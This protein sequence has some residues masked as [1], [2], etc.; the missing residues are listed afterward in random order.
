[1]DYDDYSLS[2]NVVRFG[3]CQRELCLG[4]PIINNDFIEYTENFTVHL[5]KSH[6]LGNEITV[7]PSAAIIS[8]TD[9]DGI[10]I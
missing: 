7:N 4:V 6:G 2:L 10:C 1:M 3:M 9:D 8:I 5:E